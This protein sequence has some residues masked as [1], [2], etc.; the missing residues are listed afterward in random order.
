MATTKLKKGEK[1]IVDR[2]IEVN[3]QKSAIK[4]D[5]SVELGLLPP[6][7]LA[8]QVLAKVTDEDYVAD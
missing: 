6:E 5:Y 2:G 1:F 7:G 4:M 8:N 3:N